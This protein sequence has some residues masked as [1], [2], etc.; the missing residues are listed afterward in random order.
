MRTLI[1]V[2]TVL[3]FLPF[4]VL[5]QES[6]LIEGH[7]Y[8]LFEKDSVAPIPGANVYF[9]GTTMGTT[10]GV[11]GLFYIENSGNYKEIV[12][13]F[14]G[15]QPDTINIENYSSPLS[16]VIQQGNILDDVVIEANRGSYTISKIDPHNAHT[17]HQQE[18][19]KAAC[20]NLAE[21]FETN[22]SIDASY[23]DAVTGTKQIQMLGLSGKYVQIMQ[24]NIP[25]I[26][27]LSTVY[28]FEYVPGSWI[29]S[30]QVSKGSGS[31]ANGYESMTGQINIDWKKPGNAEK[32]HLNV[33]GNQSGRAEVNLNL[34]RAFGK[35]WESTLLLH[36]KLNQIANDRNK[37]GFLDMPLTKNFIAH[38]QWNYRGSKFHME[39]GIGALQIETTAGNNHEKLQDPSF[40]PLSIYEVSSKTKRG[41]AFAKIGYLFP[42]EEYKSLAF[43]FSGV[44]HDHSALFGQRDYEGVQKS[45]YA[46]LIFQNEINDNCA[47]KFRTGASLI[48]DNYDEKLALTDSSTIQSYAWEEIVPGA[49]MEYTLNRTKL[50]IIAGIRADY[51]NLYGAFVTPRVHMRYNFNEHNALKLSAGKGQRTPN[52]IMENVGLLATSRNWIIK[53][54]V[55]LPGY[56]L[57]QE[58]A[59]NFGIGFNQNFKLLFREGNIN[60]DAYHTLFENQIIVDLDY[61]PQE[62]YFYNLDGK[63]YSN[64][65]QAEVNYDI[66]K[67]LDIRMAYRYLD[68]KKDYQTGLLSKPFIAQNRGFVNLS[69]ETKK[70]SKGG[71][72]K[73]DAT[74]QWIGKQRIPS[75]SSNPSEY[76]V[77]STS[78][79]YVMLN[80]QATRI[81]KKNVEFYVGGENLTNYVQSNPIIQAENPNGE[82]FDSSLIWAPIFGRMFYFGLRWTIE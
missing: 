55:N 5:S 4:S 76:Q 7:V 63:S 24:D 13:R 70:N 79:D 54:D 25:L 11:D 37:D 18:L 73:F 51:H 21:S 53:N 80:A 48:Y 23:T 71:Q 43:Q 60:I 49:F 52:I 75:T 33:Y 64:S 61:S 9:S 72:W 77:K 8:E 28:G 27:G 67:R 20:C 41:Q 31:V 35:K 45:G 59:W 69:Y 46:N 78:P 14:V 56:G 40:D 38:N 66:S 39:Y 47:H 58:V 26:R 12:I 82:Y 65:I 17:M 74:T 3:L 68:V 32:L 44:Y 16:I 62:V 42:N 22:P 36:S 57:N 2:I 10:T 34:N 81:I 50:G 1:F 15:F 30:I 19:R 6:K 29:N